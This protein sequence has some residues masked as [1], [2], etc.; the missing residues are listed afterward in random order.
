M[1]SQP[2][3]KAI[4]QLAAQANFSSWK[5]TQ[6]EINKV[7]E[8]LSAWEAVAKELEVKPRILKMISKQ[9]S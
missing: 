1:C 4:Q 6:D 7:L 3:L 5:K 8:A 2:T 9:L